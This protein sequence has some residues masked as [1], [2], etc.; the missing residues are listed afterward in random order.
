M[1]E[2]LPPI[3]GSSSDVLRLIVESIEA[4]GYAPGQDIKIA[5]DAA[6]SELYDEKQNAIISREKAG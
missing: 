1:K 5:I 6:A 2:A 3:L 4:S